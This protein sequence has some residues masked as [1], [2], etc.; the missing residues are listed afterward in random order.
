[1]YKYSRQIGTSN[2]NEYMYSV[3][4]V[5]S[6]L[7]I[8]T[9]QDIKYNIILVRIKDLPFSLQLIASQIPYKKAGDLIVE[10][11]E[12][13]GSERQVILDLP[14]GMIGKGWEL[15]P[16]A[17]PTEVSDQTRIVDIHTVWPQLRS[18]ELHILFLNIYP[19]QSHGQVNI[20][21]I[22]RTFHYR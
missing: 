9:Y 3:N 20:T 2:C 7:H 18:L 16:F 6:V 1:M 14:K 10:F 11:D 19:G 4:C 12:S 15:V 21:V 13:Q 8:K 5:I 22:F 17:K